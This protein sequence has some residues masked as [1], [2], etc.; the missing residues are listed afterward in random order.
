[1]NKSQDRLAELS[2]NAP[3]DFTMPLAMTL[4]KLVVYDKTSVFSLGHL[5]WFV[6][7]AFHSR[8]IPK[9]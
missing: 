2:N 4:N 6:I 5:W 7:L 8:L 9:K 3:A 1:M